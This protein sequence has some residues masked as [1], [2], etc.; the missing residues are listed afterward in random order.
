MM[1]P[2]KNENECV[3]KVIDSCLIVIEMFTNYLTDFGI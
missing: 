2:N 1:R 3:N